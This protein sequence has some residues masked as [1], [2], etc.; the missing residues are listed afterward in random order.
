MHRD[1]DE[2]IPAINR[3]GVF[4]WLHTTSILRRDA[5][6]MHLHHHFFYLEPSHPSVGQLLLARTA[7]GTP[8]RGSVAVDSRTL[9]RRATLD[10]GAVIVV[11]LTGSPG[12][13]R[14]LER[15]AETL[16]ANDLVALPLSD[17]LS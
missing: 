3:A 13:Y 5:R 2:S 1:G 17:V 7:G 14:L 15:L 6:A 10:K 16:R 8:V 12:S 4:G 9:L 11:T